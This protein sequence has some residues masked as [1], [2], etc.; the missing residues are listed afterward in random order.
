[1]KCATCGGAYKVVDRE[2]SVEGK[3]YLLLECEKEDC[4]RCIIVPE[5]T[6]KEAGG[7]S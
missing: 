4:K 6:W 2:P 3:V 7:G 5:Q 1:M